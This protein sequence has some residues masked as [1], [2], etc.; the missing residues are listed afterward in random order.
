MADHRGIEPWDA[1]QMA[2]ALVALV[3]TLPRERLDRVQAPASP[4]AYIQWLAVPA[5]ATV[6]GPLVSTGRYPA[7]HG[8][9]Y[10]SLRERL[11]RYALS[12]RGTSLSP[13]DLWVT[14]VPCSATTSALF[15]ERCLQDRIPAP[16][17]GLG[18]GAK[19]PGSRR[20]GRCSPIDALIP[21]RAWAPQ[22]TGMDEALARLRI[23]AWSLRVSPGSAVWPALPAA[24]GGRDRP[25]RL[26]VL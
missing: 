10:I 22:A 12:M 1:D 19:V 14:L 4:G 13:R 15:A 2:D 3:R 9:A 18:W 11:S 16:L 23:V 20:H 6:F 5:L 25:P 7:Y 24:S 17:N 21:G 26:R 8:V